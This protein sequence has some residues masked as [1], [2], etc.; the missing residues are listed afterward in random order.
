M[1]KNKPFEIPKLKGIPPIPKKKKL[2]E[3]PPILEVPDLS[4]SEIKAPRIKNSKKK[5]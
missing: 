4:P 5:Y 1:T 3:I 2:K